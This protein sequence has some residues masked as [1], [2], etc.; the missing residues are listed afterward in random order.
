[1][2][3][4][5]TVCLL[6][7]PSVMGLH[8]WRG[9]A[10][11]RSVRMCSD[12]T[13][14][15]PRDGDYVDIF[16]RKC[17]ELM[18]ATIVAPVKDAVKLR[19][20]TPSGDFWTTVRSPPELPGISRP[21][22]LTIAA[23]VPT[24]LVWYGYYK[25]SVE[26]ELYYDELRRE[27]RV[28]GCGGYGTLYPF[29]YAFLI[30]GAGSIAGVPGSDT[31]VEA[32]ALWILLGQVNLYRRVNELYEE[33]EPTAEPPLHAWWALLPPPLDVV[34]GLRQV[35]FL[36]KYWTERRGEA[37]RG[38]PVAEEYFPFIAE[39][40]F[41]LREFARTPSMWFWFTRDWDDF[42]IFKQPR[43]TDGTQSPAAPERNRND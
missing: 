34:V 19:D 39:P 15:P 30:G 18:E 36:A 35:H 33:I 14:P 37:W 12:W 3:R 41:T 5:M 23:S 16:C 2:R 29:V 22:W 26:Q 28:T 11:V 40:R 31:L 9:S 10:R 38:D 24:G 43:G 32:G 8:A 17:N 7:A 21:V 42:P 6:A 4:A 27:G 25:F 20:A 13:P 1:M